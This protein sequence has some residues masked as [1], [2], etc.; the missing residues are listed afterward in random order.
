MQ[1][2]SS[3][4][5]RGT[6]SERP[7]WPRVRR[8]VPALAGNTPPPP[9]RTCATPVHPRVGGEHICSIASPCARVGSSPR[10][11]GTPVPH[12]LRRV[13]QRFIPAWAGNTTDRASL[14]DGLTVH[15]R[16][17]GEHKLSGAV[18][19][20][21]AGSSP[22]GRGTRVGG[23][24]RYS[25]RRFIPAWAGNTLLVAVLALAT[26]VHPRVGGEHLKRALKLALNNGS[27]PR[28]RGTHCERMGSAWSARFIPAWAGNTM[29]K[30]IGWML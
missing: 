19:R 23:I 14:R 4:R 9:S 20:A 17:G 25:R 1:Y 13:H 3:P 12:G 22:R 27:S 24:R 10:G 8:F 29:P 21:S 28:G 7:T 18:S 6:P 30:T 26:P 5:G 15:P 11:R 16:V 2:G